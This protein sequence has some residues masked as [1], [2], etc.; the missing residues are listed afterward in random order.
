ME[1]NLNI[2]NTP[3]PPRP[4]NHL[5]LAILT[6]LCCC[7]PLGIVAIVKAAKVNGLYIAGQYE[8]AELY[9]A[10][11]RKWSYIGIG[12]GFVV[13]TIYFL[14]NFFVGFAHGFGRAFEQALGQ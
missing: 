3:M 2:E 9:A 7:L 10:D 6:T 8:A 5:V 14:V 11:A 13:N 12:I 1:E 4:D